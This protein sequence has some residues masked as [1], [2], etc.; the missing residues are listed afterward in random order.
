MTTG[1]HFFKGSNKNATGTSPFYVHMIQTFSTPK[2]TK[3]PQVNENT[4]FQ[5]EGTTLCTAINSLLS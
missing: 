2:L 1:L 3:F 4:Q 5:Q